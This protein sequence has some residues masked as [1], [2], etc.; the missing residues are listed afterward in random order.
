MNSTASNP[1]NNE[2]DGEWWIWVVFA[3][4]VIIIYITI[5]GLIYFLKT[6][7]KKMSEKFSTEKIFDNVSGN[8]TSL[9]SRI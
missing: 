2:N 4:I 9:D 1:E 5:C 6:S 7:K 8:S 3:I